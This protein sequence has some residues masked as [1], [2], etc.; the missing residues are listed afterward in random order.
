MQDIGCCEPCGVA[1]HGLRTTVLHPIK[2]TISINHHKST[3]CQ[4][5][6]QTHNTFKPPSEEKALSRDNEIE[7]GVSKQEL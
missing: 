1:I 7:K 3:P 2:L 5:D 6:A 4:A